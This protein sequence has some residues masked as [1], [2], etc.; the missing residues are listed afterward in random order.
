MPTQYINELSNL[1]SIHKIIPFLGAGSSINHLISWDELTSEMCYDLGVNKSNI[2][3]PDI[4][5][6]YVNKKGNEKFV[7]FLDKFL[8]IENYDEN[9]DITPLIIA[10]LGIGLIYTTNQDNVFEKCIEQYGKKYKTIKTLNDLSTY[11][12]GESLYIKY[13]GDTSLS[14][15]LVFTQESY[16]TR[17][18]NKNHFLNIKMKAD[19][20]TKSFLFIG[21]SFRD[22]NIKLLFKEI[23]SVFDDNLPPSYLIA[24]KYTEE[25]EELNRLYGITIIDP[26]KELPH[27]TDEKEA[28]EQYLSL[29]SEE[30]L[31]KKA[32]S[33]LDII[34]KPNIPTTTKVVNKYELLSIERLLKEENNISALKLFREIMDGS[35]I[36]KPYQE[37]TKNVFVEICRGLTRYEDIQNLVG[38]LFNLVSLE[39]KYSLDALAGVLS[40]GIYIEQTEGIIIFKPTITTLKESIYPIATARAIEYIKEWDLKINDNFRSLCSLW[41]DDFNNLPEEIKEYISSNILWAWK[42]HTIYENP[43]ERIQRLNNTEF[44]S[45][46]YEQIHYELSSLFPQKISKPYEES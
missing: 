44:K 24:Y 8:K 46:S 23:N 42:E 37:R 9:L 10:S 22:P 29:L 38:A 19:L 13:H 6:E 7:E 34:F 45:K 4:A 43:I 35:L 20:L 40:R 25:L 21:Y 31:V 26:L 5:E 32:N 30:T 18:K 28:F 33:E 27:C 2:S 41:M 3:N 11:L 39:F 15:S 17:I 36:P 14:D 16:A 12:P 1:T